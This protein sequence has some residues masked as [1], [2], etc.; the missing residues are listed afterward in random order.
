MKKSLILLSVILIG[1]I[2]C[3]A[4][5][6]QYNPFSAKKRTT[7]A[8]KPI[9]PQKVLTIPYKSAAIQG[10]RYPEPAFLPAVWF[11]FILFVPG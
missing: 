4:I 3:S 2:F 9:H 6:A 5:N 11:K 10:S 7:V 1:L 8:S